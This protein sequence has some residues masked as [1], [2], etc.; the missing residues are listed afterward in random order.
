MS[1]IYS[2]HSTVRGVR[3]CDREV[4]IS[5]IGQQVALRPEL[6]RLTQNKFNSYLGQFP[7]ET[8]AMRMDIFVILACAILGGPCPSSAR[9]A[10]A[11]ISRVENRTFQAWK[12]SV[13]DWTAGMVRI[14]EAGGRAEL[15]SLRGEGEGYYLMPGKAVDLEVLPTG[16][17]LALQIT[18]SRPSGPAA[19]IFISQGNPGDPHTL[20]INPSPAVRVDKDFYGRAGSGAFVLIH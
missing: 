4:E 3:P 5:M 8:T 15:A 6:V 20:D 16:N 9:A 19:S 18:F 12:V 7:S 1:E 14:R 13:G 2:D 10:D 17:C 11:P